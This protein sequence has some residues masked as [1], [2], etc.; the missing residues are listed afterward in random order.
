MK[1]DPKEVKNDLN[2]LNNIQ[3]ENKDDDIKGK[4]YEL[5]LPKKSNQV[6]NQKN[7]KP[8][9]KTVTNKKSEPIKNVS[10]ENKKYIVDLDKDRNSGNRHEQRIEL[11]KRKI[12]EGKLNNAQYKMFANEFSKEFEEVTGEKIQGRKESNRVES[13]K[14]I[15]AKQKIEQNTTESTTEIA[16]NMQEL[17]PVNISEEVQMQLRESAN[18]ESDEAN[19]HY[20]A[21]YDNKMPLLA[22]KRWYN[23]FY[24]AGMRDMDFEKATVKYNARYGNYE[25]AYKA[26][27]D[28]KNQAIENAKITM[29]TEQRKAISMY[30]EVLGREV[31]VVDDIKGANGMYKDGKIY[32]SS[33]SSNTGL[34]VLAHELTHNIKDTSPELYKEYE[35]TV[36]DYMKTNYP[37]E[38]ND[39][40]ENLKRIYNT[41]N[42]DEI[43]EEIVANASEKFLYDEAAVKELCLNNKT[44]GE[45]VVEFFREIIAK[46]SNLVKNYKETSMEAKML[47]ADLEVYTKARDIWVKALLTSVNNT[48][49]DYSTATKYNKKHQEIMMDYANAV[50]DNLYLYY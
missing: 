48:S 42:M 29:S 36:I 8:I 4:Y 44:L 14:N 27:E 19:D 49:I 17:N 39:V 30:K 7:I 35:N 9:T 34:T 18:Y 38:Y 13:V 50:N 32:I 33:K 37:S 41:D 10:E 31:E 43:N 6:N 25:T 40:S 1:N 5:Q 2:K 20:V 23:N 3:N 21:G 45:K 28:G 24:A 15:I 26:W 46:I 11:V 16:A 47:N 22:Y 12:Y